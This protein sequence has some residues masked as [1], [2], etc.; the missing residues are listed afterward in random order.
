[1]TGQETGRDEA[2]DPAAKDF[3]VV[4][5]GA[6]AGGFDAF[7]RFLAAVPDSTG[8]AFVLIQHVDPSHRSLMPE[9]L[10]KST[11]MTILEPVDGE[12]LEPEHVYTTTPGKYVRLDGRRLRLEEPQTPRG[13]RMPID[14]F[15]RS[16]AS[17]R[18]EKA[19]GIVL[20]G[21]GSDGTLGV[22]EIKALGGITL[23]QRP[24][25]AEYDGMP[26]SAIASKMVD[27]VLDI[28]A[29]PERLLRYLGHP[30]VEAAGSRTVPTGATP[31]LESI[32]QTLRTHTGYEFESYKEATVL[33]RVARRM[34]LSHI[35]ELSDYER[36]LREE[37]VEVRRLFKDLLIGV[38][39][40][41]RDPEAWEALQAKVLAR[42]VAESESPLR[43]WAP[44]CSTGEEAYTL[45]I[46]VSEE[47]E[48][49]NRELPFQIFATDVDQDSVGYARRGLY[50]AT[51]ASDLMPERLERYF[52]SDGEHLRV[53]KRLRESIIFAVQDAIRDAPF[54][55][56]DLV[57]CRNLLIYLKPQVQDAVLGTFHFALRDG[58]S[59]FLGSS[60]SVGQDG[61]L[62]SPI[63]ASDRLYRK[64]GAARR[65]DRVFAVASSRYPS[66]LDSP[67]RLVSSVNRF[68]RDKYVPPSVVVDKKYQVQYFHGAV[69]R[70]LEIPE[71][72]P[73][74]NLIAMLPERMRGK[75]RGL[76]QD[77]V[78]DK[79]PRELVS[80][81]SRPGN[82]SGRVRTIVELLEP[83]AEETLAIV[84][85]IEENES[86]VSGEASGP[87]G[88][89]A[90]P[91]PEGAEQELQR[92]LR[93]TRDD[94]QSTIEELETA[95]EELQT[96]NEE[97]E[98]SRSEL[99]SLNEELTTVNRELEEKVLELESTNDDLSN[100]LES[101][102]IGT[103]FLDRELRIRRFTPATRP[104]LNI[105][106]GD[107]GRVVG[108]LKPRVNDPNLLED[109]REV[110]ATSEPSEKEVQSPD[111][112]WFIRRIHPYRSTE[113]KVGGVV[114]TFTDVTGMKETS[115]HLRQRAKQQAAI[116][117]LGRA[118]LAEVPLDQLMDEV[119]Q[120][121]AET[122][123]T[124]FCEILELVPPG[125]EMI[126]RAGVGWKPG[127]IG[128]RRVPASTATHAG[129][130]LHAKAP[131]IV[132]HLPTDARLSR[133][134]LLEEH[135]VM[136]GVSV[137][138]GTASD[139]WGV[140]GAHTRE[141]RTFQENEI[142]FLEALAHVLWETVSGERARLALEEREERLRLS[143]EAGH[144]GTWD[145]DVK[146]GTFIWSEESFRIFGIERRDR[147][148]LE[149]SMA[150]IHPDDREAVERRVRDALE[151]RR[152]Y[153][154]EYRIVRPDGAERWVAD[155]ANV[156]VDDEGRP[157]RM[158]GVHI[159]VSARKQAEMRSEEAQAELEK[160]SQL[161]DE[162]LAML[163][164]ELRN[165]LGAISNGIHLLSSG[166]AGEHREWTEQMIA[167]QTHQLER[168]VDDLLDVSRVTRGLIEIRKE[169][170]DIASC[171]NQALEAVQE[172]LDENSRELDVRVPEEPTPLYAD[173]ARMEQ[174]LGN[175]LTN[176]IK[177]T[178]GGG[179]ISLEVERDG[180]KVIVRVAD[181]GKG[182]PEDSLDVIFEPFVRVGQNLK[183]AG[184]GLGVGLTL[185]KKL[186]E[187]HGGAVSAHSDG[188]DKGSE[189]IVEMPLHNPEPGR[190]ETPQAESNGE[191]ASP[192]VAHR[193]LVIDDNSDLA[194]GLKRILEDVGHEVRLAGDGHSGLTKARRFVPRA[195][196]VDIGLPGMDGYEVARRLRK[197]VPDAWIAAISG[198]KQTGE[199]ALA[200]DLFDT[201]YI[202][203]IDRR[204]LLQDLGELAP[205][206]RTPA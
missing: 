4:A 42:L 131:V 190:S 8:M 19:I 15:F 43:I 205:A 73:T 101:T 117:A 206:R 45:A 7:Q 1:M 109:A 124:D 66:E 125:E 77:V 26:K 94:L 62:F 86:G 110:L 144:V 47:L 23:A 85:F 27:A 5:I 160:A 148:T 165:P 24:D 2:G 194:G 195:V 69:G 163:G 11:S 71:G 116:A 98:T 52:D 74:S 114:V 89:P 108:D 183:R 39:R 147:V 193:V 63:S 25:S 135:G 28:E 84:S 46:L 57:S 33:R 17:E 36:K 107:L 152:D 50:P 174:I 168:L 90:G 34:G 6:S 182:I 138:V 199:E 61:E 192:A 179:K 82:G 92:E 41:F 176:A 121:V 65:R 72:R 3:P 130:T 158:L 151:G 189:F 150:L 115:A 9:L 87:A 184:S 140:L 186:T 103:L 37:P 196:L 146:D 161:K 68:L 44:G 21:T 154:G 22:K 156:F 29:M 188:V 70:F 83:S 78:R 32:I 149:E 48:R 35:V 170:V 119:A 93:A 96:S 178:E 105:I 180:D 102:E 164:H 30:W 126:L 201:Y 120:R 129:Y 134:Q 59:L 173:P 51:V 38:T 12:R 127:L 185:V 16:L 136:S 58:G 169:V 118:A 76:L 122:L 113:A 198:F 202:K 111:G 53:T 54:S 159:D 56:L 143:Q 64:V 55:A 166:A 175:L 99:Q 106:P 167:R 157:S 187:L 91:V 18:R 200:R 133:A 137:I 14:Y 191:W 60:E 162:F 171:V 128:T 100:L 177:Y 203:P 75:L 112:A 153:E 97:L 40:F 181:D 197:L 13:L 20:T 142:H 67:T 141:R 31:Q 172:L 132:N 10:S 145:L 155:R 204:Q 95:N 139:P 104:L 81:E 123:E 80:Q 88:R 79:E 49:K